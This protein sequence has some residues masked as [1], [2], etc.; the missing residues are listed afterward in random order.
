VTQLKWWAR[1]LI[2]AW[3]L[4]VVPVLLF[5]LAALVLAVPRLIGTAAEGLARERTGMA[6]LWEAGRSIDAMGAGVAMLAIALPSLAI[7]LL[8]ARGAIGA[9][10]G[11]WR[12]TEGRP[13]RRALAT[14]LVTATTA[15]VV[16]AW[17]PNPQRY[18]PVRPYERGTLF[19]L[20]VA[21]SAGELTST[22]RRQ[23]GGEITTVLPR[24]AALPTEAGPQLALV[25]VP[26]SGADTETSDPAWVFPFD[27]PLPPEP[28]DNQA[29]AVNTTDHSASYDVA[30]AMVWVTGEDPVLSTNEAYAFASCF[31]CVTVAVAFQV[32]VIV[33]SADVIVPQ[34]LSAAVN[35]NCFEC[36]TAAVASQLVVTVDSLPG[37]EQQIA[38]ADVWQ[39]VAAFASSIPT[40][41]LADVIAQLEA[42]KAEIL[43]ILAVAPLPSGSFTPAAS[44][45]PAPTAGM[46]PSAAPS[47]GFA[48]SPSPGSTSSPSASSPA[49]SPEPTVAG[50]PP[51]TPAPSSSPSPSPVPS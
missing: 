25:L 5:T 39:E 34:N 14:A 24:S 47:E 20:A 3:V 50:T 9:V 28:G 16:L 49:D 46:N 2:T 27:E 10:R 23:I 6:Q 31:D 51:V 40:L 45:S 12:R 21:I 38:L 36:I 18:A 29:Q 37:V 30:I 22:D 8:L 7:V 43:E 42:F 48:S 33:G 1:L 11:L 44:G 15:A 4:I 35:Y 17:W 13:V 19:D 41:P 32:V 26:A